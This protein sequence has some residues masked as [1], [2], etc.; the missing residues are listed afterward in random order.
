[1]LLQVLS[2]LTFPWSQRVQHV[3]LEALAL[4]DHGGDRP[5]V[6]CVRPKLGQT[7]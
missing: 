7:V 2:P 6:S 5:L 1:M 4:S 3:Q